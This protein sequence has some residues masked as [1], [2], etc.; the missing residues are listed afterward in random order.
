MWR[1]LVLHHREKSTLQLHNQVVLLAQQR[2]AYDQARSA[3]IVAETKALSRAFRKWA[4][5]W[6]LERQS[7]EEEEVTERLLCMQ[8]ALGMAQKMSVFQHMW[9][10]CQQVREK[11]KIA[12]LELNHQVVAEP[13]DQ[14]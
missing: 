3:A 6:T 14:M 4:E 13:S 8:G 12:D 1:I 11:Q 9:L 7:H 10:L 5:M 2:I